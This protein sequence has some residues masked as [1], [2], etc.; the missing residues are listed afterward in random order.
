MKMMRMSP[1]AVL[2]LT[3][4]CLIAAG[5]KSS[6]TSPPAAPAA[7][8]AGSSATGT[9]GAPA[10]GQQPPAPDVAQSGGVPAAQ[11]ATVIP[12]G[13]HLRVRLD[14]TLSTKRNHAGDKF[15]ATV[16]SPVVAGGQTLIEKGSTAS[17]TV[18]E[19]KALGHIKGQAVLT[20]RLDRV[21]AGG[22]SYMVSTSSVERVEQGKGKRSAG[23]AGGGAGFGAIIG[24]LAG[25]GKGALI[26]G[27]AGAGAGTAGGAM[28][29]N[30]D[31]V[32]PAE[33]ML[34]FRITHD[35][36]VE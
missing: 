36:H 2:P 34:I 17:G 7:E 22:R 8:P 6:T 32:L 33:T 18:V 30:N 21:R 11:Q 25:G 24:G 9:P 23:F 12:A 4:A 14:Q 10:A 13:T 15:S 28:T 3:F 31:L 29:G 26:G 27:L 35:V 16:E 20:I 1:G 19:A 5:C